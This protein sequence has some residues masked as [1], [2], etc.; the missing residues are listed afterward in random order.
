MRKIQTMVGHPPV[1]LENPGETPV[2]V[3]TVAVVGRFFP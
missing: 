2:G 3:L 1:H